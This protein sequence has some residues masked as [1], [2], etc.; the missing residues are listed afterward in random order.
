MSD[1]IIDQLNIHLPD[2]WAGDPVYLA[3]CV[4]QQLQKQA[5]LL[6]EGKEISFI[7]NGQFNSVVFRVTDKLSKTMT[8]DLVKDKEFGHV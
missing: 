2:G 3:R 7:V 5:D 1:V 6:S 8:S 4:G